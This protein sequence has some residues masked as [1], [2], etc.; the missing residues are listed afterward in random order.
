MPDTAPRELRR[1]TKDRDRFIFKQKLQ[2]VPLPAN[3]G[4]LSHFGLTTVL[5]GDRLGA[6][7][8]AAG[9]D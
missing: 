6:L 7:K 5:S 4:G 2:G 8:G 3:P 1:Y 9:Y